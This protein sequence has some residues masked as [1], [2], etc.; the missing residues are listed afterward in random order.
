[1]FVVE[2]IQKDIADV[3]ADVAVFKNALSFL[4]ADAHVAEIEKISSPTP[5]G[6]FE[7]FQSKK[8]KPKFIAF[9]GIGE[10][11]DFD[12]ARIQEFSRAALAHLS[13]S[14]MHFAT[15]AMVTHGPGY[16]LDEKEA[17]ISMVR[18][19]FE[20]AAEG[21]VHPATKRVLLVEYNGPRAVRY[22]AL[23]AQE[24][25]KFELFAVA[26]SEPT[27]GRE[28]VWTGRNIAPRKTNKKKVFLAMP[29]LEEFDDEHSA[30][31]EACEMADVL[32]ER[33]DHTFF[34]GDI[35]DRVIKG[36]KECDIFVA[37]LSGLNPNVFLELAFALAIDK[38]AIIIAKK[39]TEIPFDIRMMRRIDYTSVYALRGEVA[40]M[41]PALLDVGDH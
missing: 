5:A 18:G 28:V 30:V 37:I 12:Y 17:F 6:E 27:E 29:Y 23:L 40:K 19:I 20:A 10:L 39:G 11:Y 15:V 16:G 31:R 2:V 26:S 22:R 33:V 21:A 3:E 25:E 41:V 14:G 36:I 8:I 34:T 35:F 38:K 7:I 32:C 9:F 13:A 1:M 24:R 4:G